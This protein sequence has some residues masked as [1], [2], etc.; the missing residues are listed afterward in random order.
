VDCDAFYASVEKRDRPE[1]RDLPVIV[2]G[3]VRGVVTTCCYIARL[4]GVRSA[5]PMFKARRLCPEAVVIKPDFRKYRMESARVMA[6]LRA[7]TPLVQTLSLDEAW[8]DLRGTERLHRAFPAL[9]LARLQ[10]EIEEEVGITVSVGLAANKFLAKIASD[11]DKPRGFAVIGAGEAQSFLAGRSVSLL[12]GVGP[13]FARALEADGLPLIGDLVRADVRRLSDRFGVNG[14]RLRELALG[15]DA[16]PV[17]PHPGRKSLSAETTF[18]EDLQSL[19][20]LEDRLWPLCEKV[21]GHARA[22]GIAG[23]VVTLKL[24]TSRF[25]T[26]SRRRALPYPTQ[27]ARI[28]FAEARRMLAAETGA[29]AW[30]LI[31]IGIAD[32]VEGGAERGDLFSSNESRAFASETAID[33]LRSRFGAAAVI[34]GRALKGGD[35]PKQGGSRRKHAPRKSALPKE[36]DFHI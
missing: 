25:R 31:G 33:S 35:A 12:P 17:N 3:G 10:R 34:S 22:E 7:T 36:R 27:T 30:R 8:L 26:V 15:L 11:L 5:M 16:R 23:R 20:D 9:I 19:G 24:R 2:G 4:S 21:A 28:L 6:S 18:D 32:I 14:V 13:A 1:L 29:R